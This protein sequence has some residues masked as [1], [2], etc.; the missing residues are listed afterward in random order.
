[1]DDAPGAPLPSRRHGTDLVLR[2]VREDDDD[3][4]NLRQIHETRAVEGHQGVVRVEQSQKSSASSRA[5]RR[6]LSS[7]YVRDLYCWSFFLLLDVE[8]RVGRARHLLALACFSGSWRLFLGVC[9]ALAG[10]AA[11]VLTVPN[12]AE[13]S[14]LARRLAS[15]RLACGLR[16][17]IEDPR[18]LVQYLR[19]TVCAS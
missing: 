10:R 11:L 14:T 3:R 5:P 7:E 8:R 18:E 12:K 13:E 19:C 9:S 1:M 4:N 6:L 17:P 16:W 2:K 15:G